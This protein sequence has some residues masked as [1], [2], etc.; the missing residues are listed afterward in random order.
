MTNGE[1]R[2]AEIKQI[3]ENYMKEIR[4][5][6]QI[7]IIFAKQTD[8]YWKVVIRYPTSDNPDTM[9]MLMINIKNKEVE[10]FREG[11]TSF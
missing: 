9:S 10:Y 7:V 2:Y 5:I 6:S 1:I 8:G 11:I 3:S 4:G